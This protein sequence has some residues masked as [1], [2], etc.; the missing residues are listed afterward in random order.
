MKEFKTLRFLDRFKGF[1]EK[2]GVDYP[3]MRR[4]LQV[5]L[6]MDQR[7][8]PTI[9]QQSAKKKNEED[10]DKNKFLGSLWI[11]ALMGLM[12][13]PFVLLQDQYLFGMSIAFGIIMFIIMTTMISDFSSVLLDIR[14]K[15]IIRTKPVNQRTIS[16]AKTIHVMIY[17][18]FLTISIS[19]IP[20]IVGL[21]NQGIVFSLIFLV[22]LILLD[23][24]IVVL[25][26]MIYIVVLR[27]F[28]GEKLKDIINYV[29]IALSIGM[30]VGYQLLVRSF[31]FVHLQS[32]FTPQWWHVFIPP[33]W[34]GA[35]YEWLMNGNRAPHI[36]MYSVLALV[37]PILAFYMY[38][39]LIP[40]FE[41]SLLKLS[42]HQGTKRK[43]VSIGIAKWICRS[44]E[45]RAFY[46]FAQHMLRNERDFKLKVYPTIGMALVFPFIFI[47]NELR[48]SSFG[49]I[50]NSLMY[51]Q[52][53]FSFI[54]IPNA[55]MM[56]NYSSSY[57]GAWLFKA[58]PVQQFA[59]MYSGALKAFLVKLFLP[60]FLL[61]GVIFAII[62]GVRI[63]PD[64]VAVCLV[65]LIYTVVCSKFANQNVPFSAPFEAMQNINAWKSILLFVFSGVFALIHW[66]V[67]YIPYGIYGYVVVLLVV[68]L[69]VWRFSFK[70][71]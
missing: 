25:T 10:D 15:T 40:T 19:A 48:T 7:R 67:L 45:E 30:A 49:E 47:F 46:Q 22:E 1:F 33:V 62:F 66:G 13:L 29:Q 11:Y 14:D 60:L 9:L 36:I 58:A 23:L 43:D 2:L 50:A 3:V 64:L 12:L 6:T 37:V 24:F 44:K 8:V 4:I 51:L 71:N 31:E 5:K 28:D 70:M 26:A 21:F 42:S 54:L 27:F 65:A 69:G 16:F 32:S 56:L 57:K 38:I 61:E 39:K 59:S 17:L 41:R 35:P 52:I 20:L 34:Y 18:F 53:Y 63:I 55:V 68:N